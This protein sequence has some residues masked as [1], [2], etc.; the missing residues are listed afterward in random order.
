M[1]DQLI[2]HRPGS[3]RPRTRPG[4]LAADKAYG[5]RAN[6]AYLRRRAITAVIPIKDDQAAARR[7]K[8][9][10]GGRPPNFDAELYKQRNIADTSHRDC[11]CFWLRFS[12]WLSLVCL[13][14]ALSCA[15]AVGV[16]A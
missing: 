3:L 4:A 10:A 11:V 14:E 1:L 8:G 15:V 16:G 2:V 7:K 12:R 5:S 13:E 9:A 6:R